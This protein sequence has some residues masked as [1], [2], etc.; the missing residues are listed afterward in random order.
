MSLGERRGDVL[1]RTLRSALSMVLI[2]L[3]I[4][5]AGAFGLTRALKSLLFEVSALDPVGLL[6]GCVLMTL[7][8][9]LAA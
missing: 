6:I 7:V 1:S 8:S 5:L 4:G 2:G 3:A 9:I